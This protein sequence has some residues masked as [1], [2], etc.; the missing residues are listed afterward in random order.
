MDALFNRS[1]R[2]HDTLYQKA[3]GVLGPSPTRV[4][5][6]GL[7]KDLENILGAKLP[8]EPVSEQD[9]VVYRNVALQGVP[10]HEMLVAVI[11]SLAPPRWNVWS[12]WAPS[13]LERLAAELGR[14][15][16]PVQGSN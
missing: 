5:V 13:Y 3:R 8:K 2:N 11:P 15:C 10:P 7:R 9:Q 6:E 16:S 4:N 14:R 12:S 1:G